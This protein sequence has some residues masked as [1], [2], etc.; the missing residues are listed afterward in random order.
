LEDTQMIFAYGILT[1]IMILF[2]GLF[3]SWAVGSTVMI[4]DKNRR[5]FF[6]VV[7]AFLSFA[8]FA[9]G[10]SVPIAKLGNRKKSGKDK[11]N[12]ST[13]SANLIGFVFLFACLIMFFATS[14]FY[15]KNPQPYIVGL[16]E[17]AVIKKVNLEWYELM[18]CSLF[19]YLAWE[20][21]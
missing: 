8:F 10:F 15:L 7:I 5:G 16:E 9:V 17:G 1:I 4:A 14:P 12:I 18:L 6:K 2:I 11:M 20:P 19:P 3:T 21:A 13:G